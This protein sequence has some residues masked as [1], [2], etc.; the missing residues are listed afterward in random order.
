[1]KKYT[2]II[3]GFDELNL[4]NRLCA[5][6]QGTD[7]RASRLRNNRFPRGTA[8]HLQQPTCSERILNIC[9]DI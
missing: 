7:F 8:Y 2:E 6:W 4:V 5:A 3:E 9:E 1:M